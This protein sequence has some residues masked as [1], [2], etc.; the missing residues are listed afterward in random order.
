[1]DS[2][3]TLCW[4]ISA[5]PTQHPTVTSAIPLHLAASMIVATYSKQYCTETV[6]PGQQHK[7]KLLMEGYLSIGAAFPKSFN[8]TFVVRLAWRFRVRHGSFQARHFARCSCGSSTTTAPPPSVKSLFVS[9]QL[10]QLQFVPSRLMSRPRFGPIGGV[11]RTRITF[12]FSVSI[13]GTH[14]QLAA[15]HGKTWL[16]R[17]AS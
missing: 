17:R 8:F 16:S 15:F 4:G 3:S 7:R 6:R 10:V 9:E 1:M 5:L 12:C 11:Y 2:F 14:K 13:N